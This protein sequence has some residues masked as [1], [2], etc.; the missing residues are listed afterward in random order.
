MLRALASFTAHLLWPARCAACDVFVA[1]AAGFCAACA[2]TLAPIERSCPGC[3]AP[4]ASTCACRRSP[5][6]FTV[7]RAALLYGGAVVP[8]VVRLKHKERADVARALGR[9]LAPVLSS[10]GPVDAVLPVPLHPRRLRSRGYNQA[11]ALAR[12]AARE[13]GWPV[14]VDTLRRVRDTPILGSAAPE[15][16]RA[17]VAGAFAVSRP[18]RVR[19][20]TLLLVDDV[21]TTGATLSACAHTLL[22]AG[23]KEVRVA[24]LSRAL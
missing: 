9:C 13:T 14:W 22:G 15:R 12:A 17:L 5:F 10:Q 20:L 18:A 8:A 6:P 2:A 4:E 24:V 21:M 16:R 7:A 23:A 19:G 3:A 11:Q 1:P